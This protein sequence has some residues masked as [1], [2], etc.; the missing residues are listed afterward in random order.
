MKTFNSSEILDRIRTALNLSND[1]E[2]ASTLGIK[3]AT[4][5]NWRSR[6]SLDWALLFSFCEQIDLNWLVWGSHHQ[7]KTKQ[8]SEPNSTNILITHLD[9]KLKEKDTEIGNLREDIGRL[10]ARIEELEKAGERY[11][12]PPQCVHTLET[13]PT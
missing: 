12:S 10:K 2:L 11:V 1:T 6:N 13:A 5:S 8:E 4:L 3:K 7:N 9:N